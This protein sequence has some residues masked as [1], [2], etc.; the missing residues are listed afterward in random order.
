VAEVVS[1]DP[2]TGETVLSAPAGDPGP[3]VARARAAQ[4]G[5][6]RSGNGQP[7]GGTY[8]YAAVTDLQAVYG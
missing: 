5:R 8:V 7:E 1:R 4:A 2:Y 3:A 6:G